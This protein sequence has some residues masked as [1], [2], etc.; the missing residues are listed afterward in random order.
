MNLIL[1]MLKLNDKCW[2]CSTK[3]TLT[4]NFHPAKKEKN[5]FN[6][7]S[8]FCSKILF[9]FSDTVLW[10]PQCESMWGIQRFCWSINIYCCF[11]FCPCYT[12][13]QQK[14]NLPTNLSLFPLRS[15]SLLNIVWKHKSKFSKAL[16]YMWLKTFSSTSFVSKKHT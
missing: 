10:P 3:Q 2:E 15:T 8:I 16:L 1:M 7:F 12:S 5:P 9:V 11:S 13:N 4:Q 14:V 6:D